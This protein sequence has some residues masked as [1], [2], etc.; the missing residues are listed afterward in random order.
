MSKIKDLFKKRELTMVRIIKETMEDPKQ[1]VYKQYR[2][3]FEGKLHDLEKERQKTMRKKKNRK[4]KT[5][6][7]KKNTIER[8]FI[9][10]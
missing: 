8:I 6:L 1:R 10:C 5:R 7:L 9:M 3:E 4:E 2:R